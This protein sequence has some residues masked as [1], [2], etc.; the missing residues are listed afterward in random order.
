MSKTIH[1]KCLICDWELK[2]EINRDYEY[3][4]LKMRMYEHVDENEN[5]RVKRIK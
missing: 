4:E 1:F 2:E 5:H 3:Q